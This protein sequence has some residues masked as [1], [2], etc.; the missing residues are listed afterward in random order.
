MAEDVHQHI[1]R[2]FRESSRRVFASLVRVLRDFDLADEAMQEAFTAA[3]RR[4]PTEGTPANPT[5]WLIAA[6][7]HKGVDIIR[8]REKLKQ[9]G[10]GLADRANQVAAAN[11]FRAGEE[12]E[13]DRLRLIFTCCHPAIDP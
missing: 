1:E 13:D 3:T 8:R 12:I 2:L 5:S 9:I 6:G 4:W 11:E 10:Q 7:R